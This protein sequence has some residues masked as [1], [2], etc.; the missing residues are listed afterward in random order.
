MA[1]LNTLREEEKFEELNMQVDSLLDEVEDKGQYACC[2]LEL[3]AKALKNL[4][5]R[6]V[7]EV[8]GTYE[9][10]VSLDPLQEGYYLD[11][12]S[13]LEGHSEKWN[14]STVQLINLLLIIIFTIKRQII[15]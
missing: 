6:D 10:L 12:F 13:E 2:L 14:L 11:A 7:K 5:N 15:C 3:K 1:K 4:R 8:K 9:K